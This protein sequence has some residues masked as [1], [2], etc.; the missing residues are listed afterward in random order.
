M[1]ARVSGGM[2]LAGVLALSVVAFAQGAAQ[3]PTQP[4]TQPGARS[5]ADEQVT[6][7]GCVQRE[8]DYRKAHEAGRGGVA[9]TGMGV[10]NEF[11]LT[12]ASSATSATR[13]ESETT[14]TSGTAAA[15]TAY[16]LTGPNEGDVAQFV[17]KRVEIRGKLKAAETDVSGRPTGGA[18]AG[19]PPSGVD[20]TSKDLKLREFEVTSVREASGTCPPAK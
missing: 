14:G 5:S 15:A 19:T 6:I 18:T 4:Q 7:T 17:G 8:A 11:V 2:S 12:D 16:E 13:T 10:G 20:V 3:Q 1:K 9:G